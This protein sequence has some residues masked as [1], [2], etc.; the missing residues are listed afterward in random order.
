MSKL[1]IS[2]IVSLVIVGVLLALI[3][4]RSLS[5]GVKYSEVS[6]QNLL[7]TENEHIVQLDITNHE[8]KETNYTIQ[9][10]I[11]GEQRNHP[12]SI[13]DGQ[14]FTYIYHVYTDQLAERNVTFTIYKEGQDSPFEQITYYID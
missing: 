1:K 3:L 2:Y 9:A 5:T 8:G 7:K 4:S 11:D 13:A 14:K 6:R 12:V 10:L